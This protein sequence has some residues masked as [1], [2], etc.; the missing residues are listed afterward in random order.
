V[1]R[2]GS[3]TS[4]CWRPLAWWKFAGRFIPR[5]QP[6]VVIA[7]VLASAAIFFTLLNH[8]VAWCLVATR[9][10]LAGDRLYVDILE[11]NPPLIFWLMSPCAAL[12]QWLGLS[13]ST[14][15]GILPVVVLTAVT[16]VV[17]R[18]AGLAPAPVT[19]LRSSMLCAFLFLA[20]IVVLPDAGQRD[21]VA[22][23][24]LFPY[25]ILSGR[26]SLALQTPV[27]VSICCGMLAAIGVALKP[28]FLLPWLAAELVVVVRRRSLH[29]CWRPDFALVVAGQCIYAAMVL[30][31]TPT[32]L[33]TIVPLARATL[34][35][36]ETSQFLLL[37]FDPLLRLGICALAALAASML[38]PGPAQ[39]ASSES[40]AAMALGFLASFVL[41]AKGWSYHLVPALILA[42]VS[43]LVASLNTLH[44]LVARRPLQSVTRAAGAALI[45]AASAGL[46]ASLISNGTQRGLWS[47]RGDY[48]QVVHA[49]ADAVGTGGR[50]EP[51][52]VFSTSIW[53]AFP[54][55]NLAG[56]RWPFHYP[57]LWPLPAFYRGS[58][59]AGYHLPAQQSQQ[60]HQ[61]FETVV[62]DL[63]TTPPRILIVDRR[64]VKQA[65]AGMRFEFL[66]YF[67]GSP[68]FAALL[69]RYR[70]W[71]RA[72]SFD[73]LLRN[74][75]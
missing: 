26:T 72:G 22:A 47:I 6:E 54:V 32:Y 39:L 2:E 38:L 45:C 49:L 67:S 5:L 19:W 65:L 70:L 27:S 55:V 28:F 18:V 1:V 66:P 56:A 73:V 12:G 13:D 17:S 31:L 68:E 34:G 63:V 20:S 62:S 42:P 29:A 14:T 51:V 41:Q 40:L 15:A 50:G 30:T 9:R 8:D 48:P 61:F 46:I 21:H 4:M 35:A 36:Y 44:F 23:V 75:L 10:L 71:G 74:E 69:R 64:P 43:L 60:E 3:A 24:L 37:S 33:T 16:F 11:V 7:L 58:G 59:D 57:C 53:P 25:G 52:Y